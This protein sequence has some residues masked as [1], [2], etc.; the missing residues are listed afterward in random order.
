LIEEEYGPDVKEL[1]FGV[2]LGR[3]IDIIRSAFD[4]FCLI[5]VLILIMPI[6]KD[7]SII[8]ELKAVL[9]VLVLFGMIK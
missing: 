9:F 4:L 7:F 6:R 5:T 3:L 1:Y 8:N 2:Y